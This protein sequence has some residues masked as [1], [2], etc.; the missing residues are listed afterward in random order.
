MRESNS[1]NNRKNPP[2]RFY[3]QKKISAEII[4]GL[5]PIMEALDAGRE[6]EKLVFRKG[7]SSEQLP[8]IIRRARERGIPIQYVPEEWFIRL[9]SR[10]HQGAIAFVAAIEYQ[11]IEW[12]LPKIYESGQ[13][14]LLVVSGGITDVRNLGAIVRTAECAGAHALIVPTTGGAQ[15]N[16]DAV[17]TSA[18]ALAHFPVARTPSL[19]HTCQFLKASGLRLLAASEHGDSYYQKADLTGPV[20]LIL[21][22]EGMGIPNDILP[23]CD[24]KLRI[25]LHGQI[26]SLNVSVAAGILLYAIESQRHK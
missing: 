23:L 12:I 11:K 1:N 16:A 9:G 25:P 13:E 3:H 24:L 5:H 26:S 10:N 15:I 18:G 17:K 7:L 14:P 2:Q 19:L 20:A 6:L 22:D 8:L 21:G 4:Y